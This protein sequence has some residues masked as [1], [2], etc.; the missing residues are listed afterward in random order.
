MRLPLRHHGDGH[1]RA[2]VRVPARGS[3]PSGSLLVYGL[4]A[5]CV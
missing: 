1:G 2:G 4:C 5:D 3:G